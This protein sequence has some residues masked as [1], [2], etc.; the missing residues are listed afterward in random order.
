M[1]STTRKNIVYERTYSQKI[2]LK[3][4]QSKAFDKQCKER[5][6]LKQA[7]WRLKKKQPQI[8]TSSSSPTPNNSNNKIEFT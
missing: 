5:N 8:A 4:M 3:R 1:K 2:K 6:R 7:K